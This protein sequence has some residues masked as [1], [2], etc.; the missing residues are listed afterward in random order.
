MSSVMAT[1]EYKY[2]GHLKQTTPKAIVY[3]PQYTIY[4]L[5]SEFTNF[6]SQSK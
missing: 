4:Q 3:E 6:P 5:R 1:F 2:I